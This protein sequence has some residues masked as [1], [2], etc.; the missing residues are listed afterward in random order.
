MVSF[1]T[2]HEFV[3]DQPPLTDIPYII[4]P[5]LKIPPLFRDP[6]PPPYTLLNHGEA[7]IRWMGVDGLNIS[8]YRQIAIAMSWRCCREDRLEGEKTK[9]EEGEGWDE[10]NA[11]GVIH[12]ICAFEST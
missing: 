11:N 4:P 10:G 7:A 5:L 2:S 8:G 1:A 3:I 6:T 9:L 12:G